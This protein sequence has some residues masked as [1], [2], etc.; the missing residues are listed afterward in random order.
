MRKRRFLLYFLVFLVLGYL[1]F[2]NVKPY[3]N[4]RYGIHPSEIA[5][6]FTIFECFFTGSVLIILKS[7][8][9]HENFNLRSAKGWWALLKRAH[10]LK[11]LRINIWNRLAVVAWIANRV[12]WIL[13][14]AY[15]IARGWGRLPWFVHVLIA[16]EMLSTIVAGYAAIETVRP[17]QKDG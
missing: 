12:S 7:S 4:A 14:L 6:V 15:L 8:L 1:A 11:G 3:L 10:N 5:L 2:R 13:P 9:Y 16:A 17:D